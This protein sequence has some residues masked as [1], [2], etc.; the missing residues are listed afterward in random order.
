MTAE[1]VESQ[2]WYNQHAKNDWLGDNDATDDEFDNNASKDSCAQA[3]A[4][5][6]ATAITVVP[7]HKCRGGEEPIDYYRDDDD[8]YDDGEDAEEHGD[9]DENTIPH[10]PYMNLTPDERCNMSHN[11]KFGMCTHCDAGLA[12]PAGKLRCWYAIRVTS[13][14]SDWLTSALWTTRHMVAVTED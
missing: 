14:T 5:A 11:F 13:T 9:C 4:A 1:E 2:K 3:N 10:V 12:N 6:D 7:R 8:D